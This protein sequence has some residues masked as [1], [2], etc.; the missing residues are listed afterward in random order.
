MVE[1]GRDVVLEPTPLH[2]ELLYP[3]YLVSTGT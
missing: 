3:R 2:V 1:V